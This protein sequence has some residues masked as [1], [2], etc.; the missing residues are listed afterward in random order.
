M[1][2][3]G[4]SRR[5]TSLIHH[6]S[7]PNYTAAG[8]K[9]RGGSRFQ[10]QRAPSPWMLNAGNFQTG[11]RYLHGLNIGVARETL[12]HEARVAITPSNVQQLRK[13]GA[14]VRVEKNAGILS[15]FSD[16][17][18]EEAGAELVTPEEVWKQDMVVKVTLPFSLFIF[19]PF[20]RLPSL[21]LVFSCFDPFFLL[22]SPSTQP[23]PSIAK[24]SGPTTLRGATPQTREQRP[25]L[26]TVR[27]IQHECPGPALPAESD[28]SRS[29]HAPSNTEP[30]PGLRRLVFTSERFGL[31]S[32]DRGRE[33]SAAPFRRTDDRSGEDPSIPRDGRWCWSRWSVCDSAG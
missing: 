33:S 5:L 17:Q 9:G 2:R 3:A 29:H 8:E 25:H 14:T 7:A 26:C 31:S 22:P 19:F 30:G 11:R 12:E 27:S 16:A 24:Q 18:Y 6:N 21:A 28:L 1:F 15:G 23:N 4:I 32:C 20:L 13:R 10:L